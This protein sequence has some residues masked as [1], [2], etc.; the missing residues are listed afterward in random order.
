MDSIW[1][2]KKKKMIAGKSNYSYQLRNYFAQ[3]RNLPNRTVVIVGSLNRKK[4]EKKYA[5]MKNQYI[6]K[7]KDKYDVRY[8]PQSDFK[9]K[10]VNLEE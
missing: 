9:F 6:Y 8:I 1:V 7:N 2:T 10:M 3:E 4:I 5:K